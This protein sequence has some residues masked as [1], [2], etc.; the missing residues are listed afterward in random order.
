MENKEIRQKIGIRIP[1]GDVQYLEEAA[2]KVGGKRNDAIRAILADW[3]R[4]EGIIL[5]HEETRQ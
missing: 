2:R 4:S 3:V 5:V 1:V